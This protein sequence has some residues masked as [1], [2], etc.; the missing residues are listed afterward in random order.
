MTPNSSL[1]HSPRQKHL[2]PPARRTPTG[3]GDLLRGEHEPSALQVSAGVR[4]K[5]VR[6]CCTS[7]GRRTSSGC[8]HPC[9]SAPPPPFFPSIAL[10]TVERCHRGFRAHGI[11]RTLSI[12]PARQSGRRGEEAAVFLFLPVA[13]VYDMGPRRH[14]TVRCL[15]AF[16]PGRRCVDPAA[17][18]NHVAGSRLE[19]I[20]AQ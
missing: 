9:S 20:S 12:I 4:S 8:Q 3:I 15:R 14:L 5:P 17:D 11:S 19:H 18:L 7:L 13:A 6:R 10:D 2:S 1:V 16:L